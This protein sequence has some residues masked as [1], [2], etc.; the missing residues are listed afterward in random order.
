MKWNVWRKRYPQTEP[1]EL[2]MLLYEYM[3]KLEQEKM[4]ALEA[5]AA[6]CEHV[7]SER[8]ERKM[9][10]LIRKE[11]Y[12][13]PMRILKRVGL[14]MAAFLLTFCVAM[15]WGVTTSN[16]HWLKLY[17]SIKT[18]WED[19]F[20][21]SYFTKSDTEFSILYEPTYIPDGYELVEEKVN[22]DFHSLKYQKEEKKIRLENFR[23][24]EGRTKVVDAN[25]VREEKV[26]INGMEIVIYYYA[27]GRI[28]G[29][30]EYIDSIFVINASDLNKEELLRIYE[31][32]IK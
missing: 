27:D 1:D 5:K 30:Y 23:A 21:Y 31:G 6:A 25:Y 8:F 2:D 26:A 16:A 10:R 28:C 13:V 3:P 29:Y 22:N 18:I 20:L 15:Y 19:S 7:F 12:M 9:K 11:R 17:E 14:G 32:W 24:E 4:E